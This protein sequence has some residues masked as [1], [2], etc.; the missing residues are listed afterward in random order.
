[1]EEQAQQAQVSKTER[2]VFEQYRQ[3]SQRMM[4]VLKQQFRTLEFQ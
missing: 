4:N 3:T 1:M 2:F